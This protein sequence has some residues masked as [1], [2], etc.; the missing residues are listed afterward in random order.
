MPTKQELDEAVIEL[1]RKATLESWG[2]FVE[3][4]Q[5]PSEI[6]PALVTNRPELLRLAQPRALTAEEVGVLYRLIGG[7]LETN[8]ALRAHASQVANLVHDW[9][10]AVDGFVSTAR[11]VENFAQFHHSDV[12]DGGEYA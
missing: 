7:L 8:A 2:S 9:R 3:E 12:A 10:A 4:L 11:K 1:A 5:V 6:Y